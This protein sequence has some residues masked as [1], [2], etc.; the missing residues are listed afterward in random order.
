M[1]H[2]KLGLTEAKK[3]WTVSNLAKTGF[4]YITESLPEFEHRSVFIL[5][6]APEIRA[7]M[8]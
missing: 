6:Q 7:A 4:L 5:V 1:I 2:K 8:V 3:I